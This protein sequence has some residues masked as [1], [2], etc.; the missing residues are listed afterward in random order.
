MTDLA[1]IYIEHT[2]LERS[3]T[4]SCQ[5]GSTSTVD[6]D[7]AAYAEH[8]GGVVAERMRQLCFERVGV[9]GRPLACGGPAVASH[10]DSIGW[11]P[12]CATHTRDPARPL[13]LDMQEPRRTRSA[14]P[15][16]SA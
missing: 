1:D 12:V 13:L 14:P 2:F 15:R 10:K 7:R 16:R 6:M 11:Y 9:G 8:V 4:C 3:G 5:L